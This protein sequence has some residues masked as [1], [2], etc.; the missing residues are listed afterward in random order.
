MAEKTNS[1]RSPRTHCLTA[2]FRPPR[3]KSLAAPWGG[4]HGGW[5]PGE[6]HSRGG[7]DVPNMTSPLGGSQPSGKASRL[8]SRMQRKGCSADEETPWLAS[9]SLSGSILE[10]DILLL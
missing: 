2:S 1:T 8:K 9:A 5:S 7:R 3:L 10:V 4:G 6:S